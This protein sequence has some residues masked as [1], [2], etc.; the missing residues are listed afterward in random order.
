MGLN[1]HIIAPATNAMLAQ[2][3]VRKVCANCSSKEPA[4]KE[5]IT[6]I[7]EVLSDLPS[8]VKAPEVPDDLELPQAVGCK[9]CNNTGYK[10]RIGIFEIFRINS[11]AEEVI[12][13]NP[14]Q[15][16][17]NKIARDNGM[18]YMRQDGIM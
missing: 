16:E 7:K 6:M 11:K 9:T 18:V 10:G 17:L 1:P 14:T 5:Q 13:S 12:V 15:K 3:L 4:T 2:R 8:Y